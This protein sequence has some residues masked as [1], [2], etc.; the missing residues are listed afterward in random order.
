M[1]SRLCLQI[2]R[3]AQGEPV[4]C[5]NA[6][7]LLAQN[8]ES[9]LQQSSLANIQISKPISI[10]YRRDST[11]V[12]LLA[13][14]GTDILKVPSVGGSLINVFAVEIDDTE[15]IG[16]TA[17]SVAVKTLAG[18]V[19][20]GGDSANEGAKGDDGEAHLEDGRV[21]DWEE[22]GLRWVWT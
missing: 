1:K 6:D 3:S 22:T 18:L 16:A 20:L 10:T 9:S 21:K 7:R 19:V 13:A 8:T 14:F 12:S 17:L 11:A 4:I 15:D 2:T 5:L